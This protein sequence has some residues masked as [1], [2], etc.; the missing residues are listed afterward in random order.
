MTFEAGLGRG[1]LVLERCCGTVLWYPRGFCPSC[2]GGPEE[3]EASGRGVVHAATV[4]RRGFGAFA[5]AVPY[6]LAYVELA[7]GPLVLSTVTGPPESV[8]I[9][10]P[11]TAAVEDGV[12][13]FTPEEAR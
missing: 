10:Q 12:L 13:R 2:G 5:N 6:V 8:H 7:E 3:F 4:I 11:V 9:G 1:A